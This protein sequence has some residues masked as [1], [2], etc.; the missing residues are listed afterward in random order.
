MYAVGRQAY[1]DARVAGDFAAALD[2][3]RRL[4]ALKDKN[5][6]RLLKM[7]H[8][9][10]GWGKHRDPVQAYVWLSEAITAGDDYVRSLRNGLA[11]KMTPEQVADARKRSPN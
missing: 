5:G 11:G 8:L 1:D 10:L 9:Q 7:V 3:A 2:W 4:V 6:E